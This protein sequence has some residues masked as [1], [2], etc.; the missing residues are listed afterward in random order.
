MHS[1]AHDSYLVTEVTTAP[2]QKLQLML[3]EAAIRFAQR[4]RLKWQ[5][6]ENDQ[7]LEALVR[8]QRILG[9]M[10]SSLDREVDPGLVG[11]VAS[12]YLFVFRRLVAANAKRD[13]QD[14]DDAIRVLEVE[15]ETW[16]LVCEKLGGTKTS[17]DAAVLHLQPHRPSAPP[18]PHLET[19]PLGT[20]HSGDYYGE[21]LSL[22]G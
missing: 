16:R 5:S 3:I 14:L 7:A 13:Q 8:A 21:G 20:A 12:V 4:A 2:P 17:T 9:E 15:R 6:G 22:E 1:S 18:A 19:R 11:K 10:L